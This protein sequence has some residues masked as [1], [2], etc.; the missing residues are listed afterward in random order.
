MTRT[1][2]VAPDS[3][4]D[5]YR[6]A[7]GT[8]SANKASALL[9]ERMT[10]NDLEALEVMVEIFGTEQMLAAME[11]IT[12]RRATRI[13][14]TGG[15]RLNSVQAKADRA[16]PKPAWLREHLQRKESK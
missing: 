12:A 15:M 5:V 14:F 8:V 13:A 11:L 10:A 1:N 9:P 16:K 3:I 2:D 4:V 7:H 6:K